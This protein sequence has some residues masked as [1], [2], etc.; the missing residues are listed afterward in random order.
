M[1]AYNATRSRDID[2]PRAYL[3]RVAKSVAIRELNR[4]SNQITDFIEEAMTE[5]VQGEGSLEEGVEAEQKIQF[6]CSAIAELPPQCRRIFIMRKYQAMSQK[7][8]AEELNITVGAVEKQVTLGIKRC[9]AY[10]DKQEN[11][12]ALAGRSSAVNKE[13]KQ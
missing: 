8:I 10:V 7:A 2:H 12:K 13:Q 11:G 4:K 1:R 9:V 6:Y 3:F 5:E